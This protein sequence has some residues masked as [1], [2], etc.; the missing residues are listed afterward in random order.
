MKI[1]INKE[2]FD[3]KYTIRSLFIFEQITGKK[4]ELKNTLDN[5]IFFYALLLA[6]NPDKNVPEWDVF[7]DAMDNDPNILRQFLKYLQEYNRTQKIFESEETD[8][9]TGEK[10]N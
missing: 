1:N 2:E 10:K 3:V 5:Y 8:P 9:E 4:F 7:I 6:N